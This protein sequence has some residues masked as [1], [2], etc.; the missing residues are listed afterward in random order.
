MIVFGHRFD[1]TRFGKSIHRLETRTYPKRYVVK[2]PIGWNLCDV[3]GCEHRIWITDDRTW[4]T[5]RPTWRKLRLCTW[6]FRGKVR[7]FA[8]ARQRKRAENP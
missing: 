8:A 7:L 1:P 4:K 2:G 6:C 5:L 3:C